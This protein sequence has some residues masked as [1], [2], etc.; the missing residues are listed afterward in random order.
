MSEAPKLNPDDVLR[1][2]L[3]TKPIPHEKSLSESLEYQ[4]QRDAI[5]AAQASSKT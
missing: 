2:M 4:K 1:R 3:A 5:R